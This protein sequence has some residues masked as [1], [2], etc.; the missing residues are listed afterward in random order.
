VTSDFAVAIAG[1]CHVSGLISN[2]VLDFWRV[3]EA[4]TD[5]DRLAATTMVFS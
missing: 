2:Q 4:M 3:T 1:R 5:T